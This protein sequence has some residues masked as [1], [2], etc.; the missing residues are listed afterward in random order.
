MAV[1][2]ISPNEKSN[3]YDEIAEQFI[4][5]RD[6]RIG[7]ST[8]RNWS[9]GL[10]RGTVIL[11]LGCGNG[12]PISQALID[13]GFAIY[14]VDASAKMISE[15]RNRF[16]KAHAEHCAAEDS[17]FFGRTFDGVV[18]WGLLFLL[19]PEVQEAVLRKVAAV[20]NTGGKFLFTSPQQARKWTDCIS[21]RESVSLGI[22]EYR[23]ILEATGLKLVGE[24]VDEGEN[25]YYL[26]SKP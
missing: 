1:T 16:P 23:K 11:D 3:G 12:V 4:R 7:A 2:Q 19:A 10:P 9:R 17:L 18:A 26:V 5:R 20:L 22:A 14:G 13:E 21:E 8:V 15:F 25:Y 24:D 6:S